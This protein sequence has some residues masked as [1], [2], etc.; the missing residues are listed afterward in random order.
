[1][2]NNK[3]TKSDDANAKPTTKSRPSRDAGNVINLTEDDGATSSKKSK[4]SKPGE[5]EEK[6][7]KQ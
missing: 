6:R 5:G 1:V 3:S 4:V 2:A 7:L